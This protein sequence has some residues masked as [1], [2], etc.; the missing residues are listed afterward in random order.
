MTGDL[1]FDGTNRNVTLYANNIGEGKMFSVG[2]ADTNAIKFVGDG[3]STI[4]T[5]E[6][7]IATPIFKV[8]DHDI[9]GEIDILTASEGAVGIHTTLDLNSN[10]IV[11]V[12]DPVENQQASN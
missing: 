12:P 6:F 10:A 4:V 2:S 7:D 8:F 5:N 1:T 11:N 9:H 3:T